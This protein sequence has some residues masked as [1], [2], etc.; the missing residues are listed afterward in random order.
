MKQSLYKYAGMAV[1]L[2][3]ALAVVPFAFADTD[4]DVLA[5]AS[6]TVTSLHDNVFGVITNNIGAIAAVGAI[7][8]GITVVVRLLKRMAR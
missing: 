4:P 3:G 7:V 6:T 1:G 8:L 5:A 2:A